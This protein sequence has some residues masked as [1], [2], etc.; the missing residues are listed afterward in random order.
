MTSAQLKV[1]SAPQYFWLWAFLF[2]IVCLVEGIFLTHQ[3]GIT[4][5]LSHIPVPALG[6]D[7][8]E[9]MTVLKRLPDLLNNVKIGRDQLQL[10]MKHILFYGGC[11][12][13]GQVT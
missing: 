11:G 7:K 6:K 5:V 10:I 13:F 12:H 8:L 2:N 9:D 1:I 4:V 3:I